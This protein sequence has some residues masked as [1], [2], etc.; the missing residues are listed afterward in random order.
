LI[1]WPFFILLMIGIGSSRGPFAQIVP[2]MVDFQPGRH[3]K[4]ISFRVAEGII[5]PSGVLDSV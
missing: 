1:A 5:P 4:R 2:G 3:Q